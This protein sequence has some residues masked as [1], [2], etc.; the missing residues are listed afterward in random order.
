M[1]KR[2]DSLADTFT[3]IL[4]AA[5][6]CHTAILTS[7]GHTALFGANDSGQCGHGDDAPLD[8]RKP[9]LLK[10]P[11]SRGDKR[12]N[13]SPS[14]SSSLDIVSIGLGDSHTLLLI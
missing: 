14:A 12:S 1:P 9:K 5:G 2:L 7:D 10:A 11:Q 8:I 6:G 13:V 3:A 4:V